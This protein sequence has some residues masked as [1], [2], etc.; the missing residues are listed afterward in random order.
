MGGGLFEFVCAS[1][2][3]PP[4]AWGVSC[5]QMRKR[6]QEHNPRLVYVT[7]ARVGVTLQADVVGDL[8]ELADVGP[9]ITLPKVVPAKSQGPATGPGYAH[10]RRF[11]SFSFAYLH[12]RCTPMGR[13][14]TC[15]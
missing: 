4:M 7:L 8:Q 1:A 9:P 15:G 14:G 6:N 2:R 10:A 11:G 12:V 13:T 5:V 3:T